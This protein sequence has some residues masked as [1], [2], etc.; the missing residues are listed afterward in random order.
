MKGKP[1]LSI[2]VCAWLFAAAGTLDAVAARTNVFSLQQCFELA[3]KRNLDVRIERA[4][5]EVARFGLGAAYGAYDPVLSIEASHAYIDAPGDFSPQKHN[6]DFPYTMDTD[7]GGAGLAG[8]LPWGMNYTLESATGRKSATTDFNINPADAADYPWGIR[9]TNNSFARASMT[10]RQH[11]LKDFWIDESRQVLAIRRAELKMSEASLRMEILKTMLRVELAYHD[12]ASKREIVRVE[13]AGVKMR[14]AFL[15]ETR[16]RVEVGDQPPLDLQHAETLLQNTVTALAAAREAW[17]SGQ[18]ALKALV[19]DDFRAWADETLDPAATSS[20]FPPAAS[21]QRSFQLALRQRPDLLEARL[22]IER[23]DVAVRFRY[24]QLF[25]SLDLVGRLGSS[26]VE[27]DAAQAISTMLRQG[28]PQYMYGI[29]LTMPLTRTGQRND[30]RRS[31]AEREISQL[32]LKKAEEGVLVQVADWVNRVESRY[33]QVGSTAK[34][35]SYAE[36]ALAAEQKKLQNGLT[37]PYFVLRY[38]EALTE[39]QRAEVLAVADYLKAQAQLAF[40]EGST[41][42]RYHLAVELR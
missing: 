1:S 26:A 18:N 2:A 6:F 32:Q 19:S 22:A 23:S 3:L 12:L 4:T 30:Y 39:A 40:A 10:L 11:L 9:N 25:P 27:A 31:K 16:R 33:S 20:V 42:D 13:E 7:H 35:R 41:L 38:Q 34:A 29:V 14:E 8:L 28:D 37:T 21:L 17:V 24:N 5:S 36:A 15:G